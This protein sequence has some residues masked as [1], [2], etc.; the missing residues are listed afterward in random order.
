MC[1]CENTFIFVRILS[2]F[3]TVL[4][5]ISLSWQWLWFDR[6]TTPMADGIDSC[7]RRGCDNDWRVHGMRQS[8]RQC[9][10]RH[11]HSAGNEHGL[12]SRGKVAEKLGKQTN[13]NPGGEV[14]LSRGGNFKGITHTTPNLRKRALWLITVD[15]CDPRFSGLTWQDLEF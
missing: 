12:S 7:G 1:H 9:C 2:R 3:H 14:L 13:H 5:V 10:R 6:E 15:T 11:W 4:Y 8:R